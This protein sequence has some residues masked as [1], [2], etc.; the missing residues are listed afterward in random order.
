MKFSELW[1]EWPLREVD[2]TFKWYYLAQYA[3]W[4][5]QIFVLNIEKRRKDHYQMFAHHIITCSLIYTSYVYHMTKVGNLILCIMD[6][7]DILL[8]V[9]LPLFFLISR[10]CLMTA[11][12][13]YH[14][15]NH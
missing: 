12:L 2:G 11:Q 4:I 6:V 8:P 1:T 9:C 14:K 5:H 13:A 3:F 15:N 10:T 7:V